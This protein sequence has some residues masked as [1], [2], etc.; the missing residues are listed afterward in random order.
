MWEWCLW[1]DEQPQVSNLFLLNIFLLMR[2]DLPSFFQTP[3]FPPIPP[4][5]CSMHPWQMSLGRANTEMWVKVRDMKN[6]G[7]R[8]LKTR[9][10]VNQFTSVCDNTCRGAW[11]WRWGALSAGLHISI[12]H[13]GA[14]CVSSYQARP[15]YLGVRPSPLS[16]GS[17]CHTLKLCWNTAV[18]FCLAEH[19]SLSHLA[20][21]EAHQ[22][23]LLSNPSFHQ[24]LTRPGCRTFFDFWFFFFF[25]PVGFINLF[26]YSRGNSHFFKAITGRVV[27]PGKRY[28]SLLD[29]VRTAAKWDCRR[30]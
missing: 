18:S 15:L 11:N 19:W 4:F 9:N 10:D 17:V 21:S 7:A 30:F 26:P 12:G 27:R 28:V 22:K 20:H 6:E 13:V 5:T 16:D 29:A 24:L 2:W 14:P 23:F 3:P 25:I 8:D 1:C